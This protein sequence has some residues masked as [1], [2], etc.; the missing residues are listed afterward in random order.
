[1]FRATEN[2]SG[3]KDFGKGHTLK[4]FLNQ[5]T[6]KTYSPSWLAGLNHQGIGLGL[7]EHP[8]GS[9]L[10]RLLCCPNVSVHVP[11]A[12]R[13]SPLLSLSSPETCRT[14]EPHTWTSQYEIIV[15]SAQT[16]TFTTNAARQ[17]SV[18]DRKTR[19]MFCL[20]TDKKAIWGSTVFLQPLSV[21]M[22][23][24]LNLIFSPECLTESPSVK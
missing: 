9:P 20:R 19:F 5:Q 15:I 7:S 23:I 13:A 17:T 16:M 21:V 2:N 4:A 24:F 11:W 10:S 18:I 3:G 1:M 12:H 8:Y 14:H 6:L 22:L